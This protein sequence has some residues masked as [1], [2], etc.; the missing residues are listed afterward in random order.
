M[1]LRKLMEKDATL[2][3]DWMRDPAVNRYFRFDP[4]KA[5][6]ESICRFIEDAQATD[7]NLHLACVDDGDAY[8]GTVSLK[9][10]S[11]EHLHA[12]YA[13][14]F[15]Q[16]AQGIGAA[17]FAT[18]EI[19]RIGFEERG[20]ERIFLNVLADNVRACRFYEKMGFHFDGEFKR[21]LR[22][23][24]EWKDLRW[25]SMLRREPHVGDA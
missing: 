2:I 1:R 22:V 18:L 17:R 9:E 21:H 11:A 19:L 7:E 24:G 8:L 4:E 3:L 20:L 5:D 23:R 13:I 14:S 12:E 10:I 6:L 15:G 16:A 25:Y